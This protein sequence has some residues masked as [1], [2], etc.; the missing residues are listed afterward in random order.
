MRPVVVQHSFGDPGTGG[1]IGALQR[2]L[3][4]PLGERYDFVRM[5]QEGAAGG[6][7][8]RMLRRWASMLREVRPDLVHVRGLGNE[9]FHGALAARMA[10]VPAVL[11]SIHGTVRDLT[12]TSSSRR[13]VLVRGIE[14][15]TLA[16]ASDVVT[17]CRAMA[18]RP[19][20]DFW[21]GKLRA[22]VPNGIDLAA[23]SSATALR[24]ATRASLGLDPDCVALGVVGRLS[25]EKGHADLAAAARLLAPDVLGRVT[26][27]LV[28][29]GPD[30]A[31]IAADYDAVPGLKTLHLGRRHDVPE[32]LGALDVFVFP[33]LHENLSNALLEA[34]AAGLPVVA[35]AVGGNVEVLER[36]GGVLVPPRAPAALGK[37]VSEFVRDSRRREAAGQ[38]AREVVRSAYTLDHMVAGWDDVYTDILRRAQR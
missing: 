9:G 19:F 3:D 29:D 28:G 15:A 25:Y 7:D 12:A 2:L 11:V 8:H 10:R 1:P 27:V 35:T 4:S 31:Q 26:L 18:E 5:H 36:G 23:S 22:V 17:V 20:L 24:A 37:A 32:L 14:P 6:I 33:T 38:A 30:R 34:M 13:E 16:M 21:R